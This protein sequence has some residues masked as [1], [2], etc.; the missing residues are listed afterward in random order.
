MK[1]FAPATISLLISYNYGT[2]QTQPYSVRICKCGFWDSSYCD[3]TSNSTKEKSRWH[4]QSSP[5]QH[6]SLRGEPA[7]LSKLDADTWTTSVHHP[8][9]PLQG[10][11]TQHCF[12]SIPALSQHSEANFPFIALCFDTHFGLL[13]PVPSK[14]CSTLS[15]VSAKFEIPGL[16][17]NSDKKSR[18]QEINN[19]LG[20]TGAFV[21][22]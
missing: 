15:R 11:Q 8:P 5:E 9:A 7:M 16:E 2:S 19:A 14:Q 18:S 22:Q 10:R 13:L 3:H 20:H 12:S 1:L 17:R 4:Q 21:N 6:F